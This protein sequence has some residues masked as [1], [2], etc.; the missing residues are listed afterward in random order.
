MTFDAFGLFGLPTFLPAWLLASELPG[1][2]S[3]ASVG[4]PSE[5]LPTPALDFTFTGFGWQ[6]QSVVDQ[7]RALVLNRAETTANAMAVFFM[8]SSW[9]FTCT[10]TM[11][12]F[13]RIL[14]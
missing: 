11:D 7:A 4:P 5:P 3:A 14:Q 13:T 6:P 9:L 1:S 12:K 8:T 2:R 10:R